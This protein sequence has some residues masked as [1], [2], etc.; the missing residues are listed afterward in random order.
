MYSKYFNKIHVIVES[1]H[2][3][4][5]Q[6]DNYN[7]YYNFECRKIYFRIS[8]ILLSNRIITFKI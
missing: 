1:S 4:Q 5:P 3:L 2:I 7:N 8:H 6:F